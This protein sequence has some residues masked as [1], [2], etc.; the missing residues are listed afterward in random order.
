MVEIKPKEANS[1]LSGYYRPD[2]RF[3]GTV[4]YHAVPMTP[5][6]KYI[7]GLDGYSPS[8]TK[9]TDPKEKTK[10]LAELEAK[11]KRLESLTGLDLNQD[12]EAGKDYFETLL[13]DIASVEILNPRDPHD[14]IQLAIIQENLDNPEFPIAR[15]KEVMELDQ[16]E[17]KE[18]YIVDEVAELKQEVSSQ[19][20]KVKALAVLNELEESD[21]NK[22]FLVARILL[23]ATIPVN[24]GSQ[25]DYVFKKLQEYIENKIFPE[26]TMTIE[27]AAKEFIKVSDKSKTELDLLAT[28][29]TALAF[30]II[31]RHFGDNKYYNKMSGIKYGA[32]FEDI[33]T[34]LGDL[35]NQEELGLGKE[36][37]R[38]ESIKAQIKNKIY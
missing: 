7:T 32:Q 11:R 27:K 28:I 19:K 16:M 24:E 10:R 20:L 26:G 31:V 33:V 25:A 3:P 36:T 37:D 1:D 18:F 35:N 22:M 4:F 29:H 21:R 15:T 23:P 5:A 14:A 8:I 17:K 12:S 38:P 30:N 6:G 13:I 34:Y 2:Q 9:I